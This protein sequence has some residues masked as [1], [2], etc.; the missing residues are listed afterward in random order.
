MWLPRSLKSQL[1]EFQQEDLSNYKR[2]K[3]EVVW[4]NSE[5][6]LRQALQQA[7]NDFIQLEHKGLE[8]WR[9]I[10]EAQ[11]KLE[12]NKK[13]YSDTPSSQRHT[14]TNTELSYFAR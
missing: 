9:S 4:L 3:K 14:C 1:A 7:Q 11:Q 5:A 8:L 2:S 6:Q 13:V 10:Q 12:T